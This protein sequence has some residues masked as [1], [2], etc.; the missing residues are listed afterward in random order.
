M[1]PSDLSCTS[2]VLGGVELYECS[3]E[4]RYA[5]Y[6]SVK[7]NM[8]IMRERT[9]QLRIA[10]VNAVPKS[11][12]G[13]WQAMR[14]TG[15]EWGRDDGFLLAG[16]FGG[17]LFERPVD[18]PGAL[19]AVPGV[20]G[21]L[22]RGGV[23]SEAGQHILQLLQHH[24]GLCFRHRHAAL[25]HA[26]HA[27]GG[28]GMDGGY[29]LGEVWHAVVGKGFQASARVRGGLSSPRI[30]RTVKFVSGLQASGTE[31]RDF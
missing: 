24:E 3:P 10:A 4:E 6:E 19:F 26:T 15:M 30:L 1:Y 28:E 21:V 27:G 17:L 14:W 13:K 25:L 7:L 16:V 23:L 2:H 11:K 20:H 31:K 5:K 22:L 29:G 12:A 9:L 18:E 8:A